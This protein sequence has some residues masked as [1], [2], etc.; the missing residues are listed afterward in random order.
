MPPCR[1]GLSFAELGLLCSLRGK[2]KKDPP[3]GGKHEKTGKS[4]SMEEPLEIKNGDSAGKQ[5]NPKKKKFKTKDKKY[6]RDK[7]T[8]ERRKKEIFLFLFR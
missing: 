5:N 1:K 4:T 8:T 7:K 2:P 3:R 6:M